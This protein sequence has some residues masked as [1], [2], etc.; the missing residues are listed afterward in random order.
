MNKK[1]GGALLVL[2]VAILSVIFGQDLLKQFGLDEGEPLL[3]PVTDTA[4]P[5]DWYEIYF[6]NP[7]CPP[8]VERVGGLD[9]DIASDMLDA[10]VRVDIA[11]YDL[12]AEPIVQALIELEGRGIEVRVVT[13]TDNASLSSINQLRRNGISV[14]EDKRSGLMHDKFVVIDGRIVWTGSMNFTTNGVYCNNNNIVRINSP[15]LGANYTAEM[16][17]MYDDQ[18]FGPNSPQNTPNEALSIGGIQV[19]SY[20]GPERE[21]APVI[22]RRLASAQSEILFMAFSFTSEPIGEALLGR[23]DAGV[24][25]RGVFER[26]GSDTPFSY[27]NPLHQYRLPNVAVLTDGNP[28]VMHHKVFIIDRSMVIFGSFNFSENA[29]RSNDENVLIVHDPIFASYFLEEFETVW[30]EAQVGE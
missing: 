30:A 21:I 22:S 28:Q 15:R 9:E 1:T 3:N 10:E 2:V 8:E 4:A 29:N 26:V 6:T 5:A 20:F 18:L 11:A 13:D 24:I 16:D 17:E 12:D 7:T 14:V 25:V 27:Y 23:A 19:E